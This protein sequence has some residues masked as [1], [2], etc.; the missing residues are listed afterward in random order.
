MKI[1]KTVIIGPS[2]RELEQLCFEVE[3]TKNLSADKAR[4][5]EQALLEFKLDMPCDS[6][7]MKIAQDK[8][9]KS[10][11]NAE[12]GTWSLEQ[13]SKALCQSI[14]SLSAEIQLKKQLHSKSIEIAKSVPPDVREVQSLELMASFVAADELIHTKFFIEVSK[15]ANIKALDLAAKRIMKLDVKNSQGRSAIDYTVEYMF[16][17]GT[18]SLLIRGADPA[19]AFLYSLQI[20]LPEATRLL[21]SLVSKYGSYDKVFSQLGQDDSVVHLDLSSTGLNGIAAGCLAS[22]LVANNYLGSLNIS[23]NNIGK[24]GGEFLGKMFAINH[25]LNKVDLS[26][27][28]LGYEGI[29]PIITALEHNNGVRILNISNNNIREEGGIAIARLIEKNANIVDLNLSSNNIMD[30]GAA[31]ILDRLTKNHSMLRINLESNNITDELEEDITAGISQN[32]SVIVFKIGNNQFTIP[33]LSKI[34]EAI[35]AALE[36][37]VQPLLNSSEVLED[38]FVLELLAEAEQFNDFI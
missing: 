26:G 5:L 15:S 12:S 9:N 6:E 16:E 8:V 20:G 27:C 22:A 30:L 29:K 18:K 33:V 38:T 3:S 1:K 35:T 10:I 17:H 2:K 19:N 14:D 34:R 28:S 4:S 21:V 31:Y 23:S 32:D 37:N 11:H 24:G 7:Q 25:S 36:N 13:Y